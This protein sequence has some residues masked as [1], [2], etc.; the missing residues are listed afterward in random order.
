M[1]ERLGERERIAYDIHQFEHGCYGQ[2]C[3]EAHRLYVAWQDALT[4]N[5]ARAS[6]PPGQ[7]G[8]RTAPGRVSPRA[9]N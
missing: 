7:W 5:R 3:P 9:G 4:K 8:H 2:H 1:E 6:K